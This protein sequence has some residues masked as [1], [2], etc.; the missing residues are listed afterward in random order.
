MSTRV[1]KPA[2]YII[3][4]GATFGVET[5]VV[6]PYAYHWKRNGALIGGSNWASYTSGP[7]TM[8]QLTDK[9]SVV[10]LGQDKSEESD[11]VSLEA[12]PREAVTAGNAMPEKPPWQDAIDAAVGKGKSK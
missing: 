5:D 4:S 9:I 8:D 12:T 1:I 6:V 10:V 3:G 11:P 2:V 7:L